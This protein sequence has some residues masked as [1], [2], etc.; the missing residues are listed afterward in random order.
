MVLTEQDIKQMVAE[1]TER[2]LSEVRHRLDSGL[3]NLAKL[4]IE[5]ANDGGGSIPANLVNNLNPYFKTDKPMQVIVKKAEDRFEDASFDSKNMILSI[6]PRMLKSKKLLSVVVHELSHFVD[7]EKRT[8]TDTDNLCHRHPFFNNCTYIFK[9]TEMQARLAQYGELIEG[10]PWHRRLKIDDSRTGLAIG[11][12]EN[13]LESIKNARFT[14]AMINYPM[15]L[16][17]WISIAESAK[18]VMRR[19]GA[20]EFNDI[21]DLVDTAFH[22]RADF[23]KKKASIV[24]LYE[25]RLSVFKHKALKIKYDVISN[26]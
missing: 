22:G 6:V 11:S 7:Q 24:K 19:H 21:R 4:A 25:K 23:E 18:R 10:S 9:P 26:Q 14:P 13:F 8:K 3:R 2:V 20:E 15:A 17:A 1:C 5:V 16:V 12:M